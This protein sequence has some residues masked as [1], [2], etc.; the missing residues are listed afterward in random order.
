MLRT[1]NIPFPDNS[2]IL[3]NGL[4][5][6]INLGFIEIKD[7]VFLSIFKE[8]IEHVNLTDFH[9]KTGFECFVNK[10]HIKDYLA[11]ENLS[12]KFLI[13]Q[14]ITFAVQIKKAL[15]ANFVDSKFEVFAS[16]DINHFTSNF[17]KVRSN[18]KWLSDDIEGYKDE[19]IIV[20]N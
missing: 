15:E 10:V 4:G 18:E 6:V 16:F 17:H 19:S 11:K 8:R 14:T 13:E 2:I 7:S 9:D 3:D 5:N 20:L 1:F 12:K